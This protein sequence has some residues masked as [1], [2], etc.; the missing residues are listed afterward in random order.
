MPVDFKMDK[1]R[2]TNTARNTGI[3]PGR[4]IGTAGR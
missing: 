3:A 4:D 2:K 1:C